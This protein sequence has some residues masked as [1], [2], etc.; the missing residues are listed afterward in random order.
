MFDRKGLKTHAGN[1]NWL[2]RIDQAPLADRVAIDRAPDLTCGKDRAACAADKTGTMVWMGMGEQNGGGFP[3]RN[4]VQ[5]IRAAIDD[6][7]MATINNGQRRVSIVLARALL[8]VS[9]S[10]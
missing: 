1:V 2:S 4:E 9:A 10:S 6:N 3:A 7:F 5:P 8:Y